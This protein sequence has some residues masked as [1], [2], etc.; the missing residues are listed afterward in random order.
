MAIGA[1]PHAAIGK[2]FRR[3]ELERS[4]PNPVCTP[5][6]ANFRHQQYYRSW[7][8]FGHACSA[9]RDAAPLGILRISSG[10][11]K[12]S[13]MVVRPTSAAFWE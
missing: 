12:M 4:S 1:R 3:P 13:W 5:I 8:T 11:I 6:S 2:H 10:E 9:S 7:A